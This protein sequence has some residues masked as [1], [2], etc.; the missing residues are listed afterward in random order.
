M[1]IDAA[2]IRGTTADAEGN[3]VMD[4]EALTLDSLAMAM[5]A[6]NSGGVVIAQ[7]EQIAEASSLDPRQVKVPGIFI[8]CVVQSRPENHV[9]TYAT[10]YSPVYAGKIRAPAGSL[11]PCRWMNVRSLPAEPRWSLR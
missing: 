11:A 5:A 1:P 9:Q 8:D 4:R 2:L 10:D 6:R 7:V 3:L